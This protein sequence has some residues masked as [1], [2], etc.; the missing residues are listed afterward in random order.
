MVPDT[1]RL[2]TSH[3][4]DALVQELYADYRNPAEPIAV[5]AL[6]CFLTARSDQGGP[7]LAW[8]IDLHQTVP[9]EEATPQALAVAWSQ[10]LALALVQLE[11][12][13]VQALSTP[14]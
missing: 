11:E 9:L 2:P 12:G 8:Q 7:A 10:A 6:Q 3:R 14:R 13:L 1:S 5:L 4:L